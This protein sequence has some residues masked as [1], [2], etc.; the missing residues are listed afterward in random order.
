MTTS[1]QSLRAAGAVCDCRFL[2]PPQSRASR[3]SGCSRPRDASDG[4][5]DRTNFSDRG[6]V[7]AVPHSARPTRK[8]S[9]KRDEKKTFLRASRSA[10]KRFDDRR[11]VVLKTLPHASAFTVR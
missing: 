11:A 7:W 5:L 4:A 9:R 8:P 10:R 6:R 2:A 3:G 1:S